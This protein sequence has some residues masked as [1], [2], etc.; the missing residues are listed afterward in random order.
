MTENTASSTLD[1]SELL[2]LAMH[3]STAGHTGQSIVYLKEAVSRPD[4]SGSANFLL[5]AEYATI[6]MYDRALAQ[7]EAALVID[8]TLAIA[9]FQLGL[10]WLT[11]GNRES[12]TKTL[13][14]LLELGSQEPLALFA[15]GLLFLIQ[16]RFEESLHCLQNGMELNKS[17]PALNIDMQKIVDRIKHAMSANAGAKEEEAPQAET[18]H[19]LMS[20][21]A[22]K[23]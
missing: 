20:A 11:S 13:E 3:S 14:P 18:Q 9:R 7:M 2:H 16:D 22:Q 12:A 19:V 1:Q 4:A 5:G 8:P 21:Y 15:Q 23:A 6:G 17:N 10:L